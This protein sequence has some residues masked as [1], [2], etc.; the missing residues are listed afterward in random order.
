VAAT[1]KGNRHII[2][3]I[4][5]FTKF[6][7]AKPVPDVTASV[8]VD[9]LADYCG[10]FGV[11][12][13]I[14][15]D[16]APT[17]TA[18]IA[19]ELMNVFRIKHLTAAPKHSKGNATVERAIQTLQEKVALMAHDRENA[20]EWD[21]VIPVVVLSINNTKH[22][23]TGC[24]PF[25]LT[26]GRRPP[27]NFDQMS[28]APATSQ[29]LYAKL[30]G[31][32]LEECRAKA[33]E[34]H[35]N[36]NAASR[37]R[38][39][40]GRKPADFEVGQMVLIRI[41]DRGRQKFAPRYEGPYEIVSRERDICKL[42]SRATGQTKIRHVSALKAY[43]ESR[44]LDRAEE[45]REVRDIVDQG[46]SHHVNL[47]QNSTTMNKGWSNPWT[48]IL[49]LG[50]VVLIDAFI[51]ERASPIVWTRTGN[52][53]DKGLTRFRVEVRY[54]NPCLGLRSLKTQNV[55]NTQKAE[56]H[57]NALYEELIPKVIDDMVRFAKTLEFVQ[58][59][60]RRGKRFIAEFLTGMFFSN[61]LKTYV[62]K[63]WPDKEDGEL[64]ERQKAVADKLTELNRNLNATEL[65][66]TAMADSLQHVHEVI[67]RTN[68]KLN[69]VAIEA[70]DIAV[71]ASYIVSKIMMKSSLLAKIRYSFK[72]QRI[73]LQAL[74]ELLETDWLSDIH[75]GS[76]IARNMDSQGSGILRIE[77]SGRRE[78][79]NTGI[80]R[81]DPFR[82][83]A[84][85][86]GSPTL[87][88]Y[89]GERYLMFNT[90]A[91]CIKAINEP[92]QPFVSGVC[93]TKDFEDPR[94]AQW[95]KIFTVD[96]LSNQQINT[97]MKESY[98][99]LFVYCINQHITIQGQTQRCPPYVFRINATFA[100]NTTDYRYT[101]LSEEFEIED[102]YAK[103][104]SNVHQV[105]FRNHEDMVDE[106]VAIDKIAELRQNLEEARSHAI[107]IALP[108]EGGGLSYAAATKGLVFLFAALTVVVIAM[109]VHGC[110][111]GK[112]RHERVLK[113]V[114]DGL[115]GEGTYDTVRSRKGS[116]ST[117]HTSVSSS[118]NVVNVNLRDFVS[119]I[120]GREDS[121]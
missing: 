8:F 56:N 121:C 60:N 7:E 78:A 9:F 12:R 44:E 51:F 83:W 40:A 73:D 119:R 75:E 2:V 39:L 42:K 76:V 74:S 25:E 61:I 71:T 4:D 33:I 68:E 113:T 67:R 29:D 103:M 47:I 19:K 94:L 92:S 82:Y 21:L 22:R 109:A 20:S 70:P 97:T 26:F 11:P 106:N 69:L 59:A 114:M 98:P 93:D 53:V 24:T 99:Y 35:S 102:T 14:L 17:F 3:A 100:W 112:V 87:M 91:N 18:T 55:V 66:A 86:T 37:Q 64:R 43:H 84:N 49:F 63:I 41:P 48:I 117:L 34:H 118:P 72:N 115:H 50:L 28:A 52:Y 54:I 85:L 58:T 90:S 65:L 79:K 31:A 89:I 62:D 110:R 32:H 116:T 80:Y 1:L 30:I 77:F 5:S 16:N 57:C 27:L 107:A 6:I 95:R 105:H 81:V 120:T 45:V 23:S 36:A 13:T 108:T 101:P 10:R 111:T 15:T 96:N 38:Y 104:E 88:E 46:D